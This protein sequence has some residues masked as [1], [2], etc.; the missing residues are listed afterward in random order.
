MSSNVEHLT[1]QKAKKKEGFYICPAGYK[2]VKIPFTITFEN[3]KILNIRETSNTV[4]IKCKLMSKFMDELNERIIDLVRENSG[5]WFNSTIDDEL[6][7]EYY[8]STLQYDKKRGETLRLK[9]KNIDELDSDVLGSKGTLSVCLKHLKFYKQKFFPEF[10]IQSFTLSSNN[11]SDAPIFQC[12]SDEEDDSDSF[13]ESEDEIPKPTFEEV[14]T[15]KLEML[16][17]LQQ[18][19]TD[20]QSQLSNIQ[21]ALENLQNAISNLQTSHEPNDIIKLCESYQNLICE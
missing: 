7:E 19:R 3:A 21:H 16:T 13:E 17:K 14:Q 12:D 15:I 20:L 2:S 9:V 8:I 11:T 5:S 1:I 18:N 10:D 4:I 6:I